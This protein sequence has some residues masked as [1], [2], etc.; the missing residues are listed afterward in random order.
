MDNFQLGIVTGMIVMMVLIT[1]FIFSFRKVRKNVD[2]IQEVLDRI[3]KG[4]GN[5][6]REK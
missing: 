4:K 2:I 3:K 6:G 1:Y 5:N